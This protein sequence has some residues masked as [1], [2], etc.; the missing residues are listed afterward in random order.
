MPQQGLGPQALAAGAISQQGWS[1][2]WSQVSASQ[3]S[4]PG[5]MRVPLNC[6]NGHPVVKLKEKLQQHQG[7]MQ[8]YHCDAC[9]RVLDRVEPRWRCEHHCKFNVCQ[10]CFDEQQRTGILPSK[11]LVQS[12]GQGPF[13]QQSR[14]QPTAANHNFSN[15]GA[16]ALTPCVS[17]WPVEGDEVQCLDG[18]HM[19]LDDVSGNRDTWQLLPG[20]AAF[21][22][23]VNQGGDFRLRNPHG[24]ET[25]FTLR[26]NYGYSKPSGRSQ[27]GQHGHPTHPNTPGASEIPG[28][29]RCLTPREDGRGLPH[30]QGGV[31]H[32]SVPMSPATTPRAD[33]GLRSSLITHD[34]MPQASAP[35]ILVVPPNNHGGGSSQSLGMTPRIDSG[36]MSHSSAPMSPGTTPRMN[37]GGQ[38]SIPESYRLPDSQ[39]RVIQ[40]PRLPGSTGDNAAAT[41][42]PRPVSLEAAGKLVLAGGARSPREE[43]EA[44]DAELARQMAQGNG[45]PNHADQDQ[46][47]RDAALAA[48]LAQGPSSPRQDKHPP[49]P[50]ASQ[51]SVSWQNPE[52]ESRP[53][54]PHNPYAYGDNF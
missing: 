15:S 52:A 2:Q 45:S 21:V 44:R 49:S 38:A 19:I 18:K 5:G 7:L 48:E 3:V 29:I 12:M 36:G 13:D 24:L 41:A 40:T 46:E 23:D 35:S 34:G 14:S 17:R 47:A 9:A 42:S 16:E 39:A 30:Q 53:A 28:L 11:Q 33:M 22:V 25:N 50:S 31:P 4:P 26:K 1:S 37:S 10:G 27:P 54:R 8:T 6:P 20:Q 43:Q 51:R 32:S